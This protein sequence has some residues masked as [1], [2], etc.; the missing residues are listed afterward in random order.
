[1]NLTRSP[2]CQRLSFTNA[3]T[4]PHCGKPFQP[5]A[6]TAK[7]LGEDKAFGKKAHALFLVAFLTVPLVLLFL[8][9]QVYQ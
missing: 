3:P 8:G 4:C 9:L 7:E 1:M 5:G 6:L 2:C